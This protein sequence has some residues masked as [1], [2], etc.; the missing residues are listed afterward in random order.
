MKEKEFKEAI[1][2]IKEFMSLGESLHKLDIDIINSKLYDIPGRLF[3]MLIETNFTDE[4]I[5]LVFW[6]LYEDVPKEVT[7]NAVKYDLESIDALWK[8]LNKKRYVL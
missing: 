7:D 6:W 4:G 5:D 2:L 8:Y 3:D 1:S